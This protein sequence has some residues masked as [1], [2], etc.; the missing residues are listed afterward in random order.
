MLYVAVSHCVCVCVCVCA[1]VCVQLTKWVWAGIKTRALV[2]AHHWHPSHHCAVLHCS[3]SRHIH[4]E[5]SESEEAA[6][7]VGPCCWVS[8]AYSGRACIPSGTVTHCLSLL[9]AADAE[10]AKLLYAHCAACQGR[11]CDKAAAKQF[12]RA[13]ADSRLW[14]LHVWYSTAA[15]VA[16]AACLCTATG[17]PGR[18]RAESLAVVPRTRLDKAY[19]AHSGIVWVTAPSS[20]HRVLLMR[21]VLQICG[22]TG[23]LRAVLE[24][25]RW[26]LHAGEENAASPP[27]IEVN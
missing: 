18:L 17:V 26:M 25:R 7:S 5:G 4:A 9:R 19:L 13:D 1:C 12:K 11:R 16:L 22:K 14:L 6:M 3:L 2:A 23:G 27:Q 15:A 21:V 24:H 8:D 10:D 20:K